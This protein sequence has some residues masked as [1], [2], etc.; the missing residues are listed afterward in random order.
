MKTQ[1]G[2]LTLVKKQPRKG[3]GPKPIPP[4]SVYMVPPGI[5]LGAITSGGSLINTALNS[6]LLPELHL[7][8]RDERTGKIRKHSFTGPGTKLS[9]R[10]D[11]NG[12]PHPWSRPINRV[13]E[14]A[15]E[16]DKC[17]SRSTDTKPCDITM[18]GSL[19]TVLADPTTH[20]LNRAEAKVVRAAINTKRKYGLGKK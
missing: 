7:Y 2:G 18:V 16:H 15:L 3:P 19:D 17:Y 8:G 9:K 10:L 11:A 12:K 4:K 6:G 13:D 5:T 14:A 20:W 1:S